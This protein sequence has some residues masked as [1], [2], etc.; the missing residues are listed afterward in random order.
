VF[1]IDKNNI[2]REIDKGLTLTPL[3]TSVVLLYTVLTRET[4]WKTASTSVEVS[5]VTESMASPLDSQRS[6]A[7]LKNEQNGR[8]PVEETTAFMVMDTG[9]ASGIS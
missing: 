9:L 4:G 3:G 2:K 8:S 6:V 1:Y 7:S 5:S